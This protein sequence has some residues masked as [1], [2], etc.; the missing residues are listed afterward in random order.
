MNKKFLNDKLPPQ[1]SVVKASCKLLKWKVSLLA[2]GKDPVE[3]TLEGLDIVI[4]EAASLQIR[5]AKRAKPAAART[6]KDKAESKRNAI[7]EG[8]KILLKDISFTITL[9]HSSK[10]IIHGAPNPFMC[11]SIG[12][13]CVHSTNSQWQEITDLT[14]VLVVNPTTDEAL[15][16]KRVDI[17]EFS[18]LIFDS[19]QVPFSSSSESSH[20]P[21][22]VLWKVDILVK[23]SIK[24]RCTDFMVLAFRVDVNLYKPIT[25]SMSRRELFMTRHFVNAL[26]G[27]V[28][29]GAAGHQRTQSAKLD[30]DP[31]DP[32]GAEETGEA[33]GL[34]SILKEQHNAWTDSEA[35]W[36]KD[37][38]DS[39]NIA[40]K[41]LD[42]SAFRD[43]DSDSP[44]FL[45]SLGDGQLRC[46][47]AQGVLIQ[48]PAPRLEHIVELTLG[49]L[50]IKETNSAAMRMPRHLS[51]L[52]PAAAAA[53]P[54]SPAPAPA[55]A[56][57][58][59][60]MLTVKVQAPGKARPGVPPTPVRLDVTVA[61][62]AFTLDAVVWHRLARFFAGGPLE[63]HWEEETRH[64]RAKAAAAAR[65]AARRE[66]D[67]G[68]GGGAGAGRVGAV[69]AVEVEAV[70]V[71]LPC[72]P[73]A[74]GGG[75]G[76]ADADA[77]ADA[78]GGR[79]VDEVVA[80]VGRLTVRARTGARFEPRLE[81]GLFRG[82]G[83]PWA[84]GDYRG[85]SA[86][87][88]LRTVATVADADLASF[89]VRF[90]PRGG[91]G[92]GAAARR[93]ALSLGTFRC[94][95]VAQRAPADGSA[96]AASRRGAGAA[97]AADAAADAA[98]AGLPPYPSVEVWADVRDGPRVVWGRA[99]TVMVQ[100][101]ARQ[102]GHGQEAAAMREE[103]AQ[104]QAIVRAMEAAAKGADTYTARADPKARPPAGGGPAFA[105]AAAARVR[106]CRVTLLG[107]GGAAA[108]L[109]FETLELAAERSRRADVLRLS[110]AGLAVRLREPGAGGAGGRA[111]AP[112]ARGGAAVLVR[113][114]QRPAEGPSAAAAGAPPPPALRAR[115]AAVQVVGMDL[116]VKLPVLQVRP[117]RVRPA[118]VRPARA[119]PPATP[120]LGSILSSHAACPA[121]PAP[122]LLPLAPSLPPPLTPP[123]P[124]PSPHPAPPGRRRRCPQAGLPGP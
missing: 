42:L 99:E 102:W 31:D 122:L 89:R 59:R 3:L 47:P 108:D 72:Y 92:G 66:P 71:V 67:A 46:W 100:R 40:L 8:V 88:A 1:F 41:Q 29:R 34:D 109:S 58:P 121:P 69:L 32:D 49:F 112:G 43:E 56:P 39:V 52:G 84:P 64:S 118:R 91:G 37:V 103:E 81:G 74:G 115:L 94:G 70:T 13:I 28:A 83:F 53:E 7:L 51:M 26:R 38:D 54:S 18:V 87:D 107:D 15:S 22:K 119:R 24:R 123:T 117:A 4:E 105:L 23:L 50:V 21:C 36:C 57:G 33:D 17:S 97:A 11:V 19:A 78:G 86:A 48:T 114:E 68:R 35:R 5:P 80:E 124:P 45:V 63:R 93:P 95:G 73:D 55:P 25:I 30:D 79:E 120:P 77:D 111:A 85:A 76:A 9:L 44:G 75:G 65:P 101:L 106:G 104:T 20:E 110:G 6:E 16:F 90:A 116:L 98:G 62:L 60:P 113:V 61:P 14:K 27:A 82:E 96:P 2:L 10:H 12:R